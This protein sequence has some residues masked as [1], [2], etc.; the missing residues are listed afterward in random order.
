MYP[1]GSVTD[2]EGPST[3]LGW[4]RRGGSWLSLAWYVRSASCLY[5][6]P[7][8]RASVAG[9]RLVRTE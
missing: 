1:T 9:F 7:G 4:V 2:P 5:G 6:P 3:G 8:G